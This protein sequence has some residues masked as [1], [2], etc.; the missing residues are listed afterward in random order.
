MPSVTV[1]LRPETRDA[2]QTL[3]QKLRV[4]GTRQVPE[5]VRDLAFNDQGDI[6]MDSVVAM[7][8]KLLDLEV[9]RA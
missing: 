1:R 9:D 6:T 7:A 3:Q 2:I 4:S 8:V 5:A